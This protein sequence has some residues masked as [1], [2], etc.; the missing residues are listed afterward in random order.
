MLQ[1]T[2][3]K[4]IGELKENN[5]KDWFESNRKQYESA[6]EN[7]GETV[8]ELIAGL[9]KK[10]EDIATLTAKDCMFRINRDV[11][12]SKDKSPYKTNFGASINRGGKKSFFAGYYFHC[13]PGKSFAGGG[14]WMPETEHLKKIRQEIDYNWEDFKK[15]IKSKSFVNTYGDLNKN[16]EATLN[17]EPKG[18]D[19]MNPAIEYIKLKCWIATKPIADADLT[20]TGAT[21]K[22]LS[23]FNALLPLIKFLNR[24]IE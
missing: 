4:F 17:R 24:A 12:F 1:N 3:L 7:F 10:D 6:K 20:G 5:N 21:K 9:S 11:R 15:I 8:N 19:K 16:E 2:T 13:E 18:Y 23:A 14:L 22:I